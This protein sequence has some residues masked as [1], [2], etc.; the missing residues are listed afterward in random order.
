[1]LHLCLLNE[2]EIPPEILLFDWV[3]QTDYAHEWLLQLYAILF[4]SS[5]FT[6]YFVLRNI[7]NNNILKSEE[8]HIIIFEY[9]QSDVIALP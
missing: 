7:L 3:E 5:M 4:I 1:M 8:G 2:P 6:D 9:D